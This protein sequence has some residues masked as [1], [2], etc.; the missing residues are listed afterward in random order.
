MRTFRSLAIAALAAAFFVHLPLP[1][2]AQNQDYFI[3][4]QQKPAVPRP[5]PQRQLAPPGEAGGAP[6]GMPPGEAEAPPPPPANVDLPPPPELPPVAKGEAPPAA[7]IGVLGVPEVMRASTAAQEVE[8]TIGARRNK[9]NED[10]QKEQQAWRDMQQ[11]LAN[12]RTK[13]NAEQ[14]RARERALQERITNAQRT[15]R[16]RNRVIQEAAQYALAQI[17]RTLVSVIRQVSESR[18]MNLV[19]HR[20]QVALNVN[21]FDITEQVTTQ[22]N[23]VLPKVIVPP[24][25]VTPAEMV[26]AAKK[27]AA[28]AAAAKPAVPAVPAAPAAPAPATQK[29]AQ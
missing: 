17:E 6:F 3:P 14:I 25:G 9:L 28:K 4:G 27:E 23:K 22:L 24:D 11:A 29:P 26:A 10:A 8:K 7:V 1:A 12:D 15:F 20:S 21:Q 19:L 13:L 2:A 18:G 5:P 16:E